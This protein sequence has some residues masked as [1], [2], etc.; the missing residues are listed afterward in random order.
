M[1]STTMWLSKKTY[2]IGI[3]CSQTLIKIFNKS[4]LFS[5]SPSGWSIRFNDGVGINV[6][7]KP[8]FSVR[9]GYK[10][11]VKLGKYYIVKL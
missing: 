1:V 2:H 7:T 5:K 8:L 3:G 6:T 9:N 11:R 10:N 4:I